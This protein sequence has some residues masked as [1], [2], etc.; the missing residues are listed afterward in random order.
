MERF[1]PFATNDTEIEDYL[2]SQVELLE[3]IKEI[4]LPT[5]T[6]LLKGAIVTIRK[7]K[8]IVCKRDDVLSEK[9][10]KILK[11]KIEN[12]AEEITSTHTRFEEKTQE[13]LSEHMNSLST[14]L[15]ISQQKI[16]EDTSERMTTNVN[17]ML[18]HDVN[19]S[20][21]TGLDQLRRDVTRCLDPYDLQQRNSHLDRSIGELGSRIDMLKDSITTDPFRI[22]LYDKVENLRDVTSKS[23]VEL[24]EQLQSAV[25]TFS[26]APTNEMKRQLSEG[27]LENFLRENLPRTYTIERKAKETNEL[28][29]Q[30]TTPHNIV[31]GIDVKNW[32]RGV[33]SSETKK[34]RDVMFRYSTIDV[35]M[36]LSLNSGIE[37]YHQ[38]HVENVGHGRLIFFYP[39]AMEEQ[40]KCVLSIVRMIDAVAPLLKT[41]SSQS[42]PDKLQVVASK[43][44]S[45]QELA[46]NALKVKVSVNGLEKSINTLKKNIDRQNEYIR[47][48][49]NECTEA[50][51]E[52]K[53][54]KHP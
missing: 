17:R 39:H 40:C 15:Q 44:V 13:K 35:G 33:D 42:T 41:S 31:F 46:R 3:E 25:S 34:F 38:L 26:Y 9:I 10:E 30:I 43:L 32:K 19:S 16:F 54:S 47:S 2:S 14:R 18:R 8:E 11:D 53:S 1:R 23:I 6:S 45:I 52:V 24:R 5:L 29:I 37:H 22:T 21:T 51:S 28:D 50:I 7:T 49:I 20:L 48:L 4:S 12:L 27:F 36:I